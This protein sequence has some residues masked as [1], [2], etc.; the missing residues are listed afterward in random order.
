[1]LRQSLRNPFT[2]FNILFAET[3]STT[4]NATN[5][6]IQQALH[7]SSILH[8]ND[9]SPIRLYASSG[10]VT[11]LTLFTPKATRVVAGLDV[12][13]VAFYIQNVNPSDI[14]IVSAG[15]DVIPYNE[16]TSLRSTATTAA[17]GNFIPLEAQSQDI[18]GRFTSAQHG[19]LQISG[20]GVLEVIAGRNFDL[21]SG[22]NFVGGTGLGLTSIG[23]RRN[24]FLPFQGASLIVLA[25]VAGIDG[26]AANGLSGS[27]LDFAA[28]TNVNPLS[29][30]A[31]SV[32]LQSLGLANNDLNG[33][34]LTEE[35]RAIIALEFFYSILRDSGREINPTGRYAK[36]FAAIDLLFGTQAAS[37]DIFTRSRD[38]RTITG[39]EILLNAPAGGLTLASDIFGNPLT[40]PGVVTEFGG[41][42]SI[43]TDQSVNIGQ[44]RIFTLRGGDITIWAS[45]GD[46]A[47][48]SAPRT[49]VTAPPT[50]V[51][52][53]TF[54]ASVET[55]LGG[56]ATG[57]GIG[58]LASVVG[59][60]P[61]DV[62]L[63]APF[64]TVDAGDAGI[65]V[66]GNIN[67]AAAQILNA[68]NIQVAGTSSGIPTVVAP[69]VNLAGLSSASNTTAAS[70]AAATEAT[71]AAQTQGNQTEELPSIIVVEVLGYGG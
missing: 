4:G 55:D 47:A 9:P 53:E 25:G 64:G 37:G 34:S 61:G 44:S 30:F 16:N 50:R 71:K 68:E 58:V 17:L 45:V 56:L 49:V 40:P 69:T 32:Y 60:P 62:D 59:V 36:G 29:Q 5:P 19:D 6:I 66:T 70:S 63:I 39:G 20:P 14:S 46:I 3:G 33:D 57:G 65:R 18:T 15:R 41:G 24:P 42:I 21:G 12:T 48:G 22:A 43:F 1:V 11:G 67:I 26:G 52:I 23:S 13:D 27:M 31:D 54:S 35:Q 38:I 28:F 8:R 10:D 7:D 2:T 51:V